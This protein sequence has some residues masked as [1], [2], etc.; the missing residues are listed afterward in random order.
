M[1]KYKL[2]Y[3]IN[4]R[5][6]DKIIEEWFE[7]L[8]NKGVKISWKRRKKKEIRERIYAGTERVI[9][10]T[11]KVFGDV[12]RSDEYQITFRGKDES[13]DSPIKSIEFRPLRFYLAD[14]VKVR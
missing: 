8:E 6:L 14:I 4:K 7:S 1:K 11:L 10:H 2:R 13:E 12:T 5:K 9:K 3:K